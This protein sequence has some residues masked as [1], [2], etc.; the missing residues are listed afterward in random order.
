[1]EKSIE[2]IG[3]ALR[4]SEQVRDLWK[5]AIENMKGAEKSDNGER[6]EGELIKMLKPVAKKIE[7]GFYEPVGSVRIVKSESSCEESPKRLNI[8]G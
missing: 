7:S 4:L 1:M 5:D 6:S 2:K 8:T 3:I